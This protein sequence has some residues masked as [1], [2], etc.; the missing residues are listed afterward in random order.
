MAKA[1]TKAKS[2]YNKKTYTT[3]SFR[4]KKDIEKDIIDYINSLTNKNDFFK[5]CVREKMQADN[6]KKQNK[7]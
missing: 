2:K 4:L 7:I 6:S 1:S 5:N 3:F